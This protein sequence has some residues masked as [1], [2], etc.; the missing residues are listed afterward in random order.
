[1]GFLQIF[2]VLVVGAQCSPLPGT[3]QEE[4]AARLER[5]RLKTLEDIQATANRTGEDQE[6]VISIT[7][8]DGTIVVDSRGRVRGNQQAAARYEL[9]TMQQ[10]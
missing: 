4:E 6:K 7:G 10:P 5:L 1:M 3:P 9:A 2:L 8:V